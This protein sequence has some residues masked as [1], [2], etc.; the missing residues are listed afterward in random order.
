[1]D[2]VAKEEGLHLCDVEAVMK[3]GSRDGLCFTN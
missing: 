3:N 2:T 1:M